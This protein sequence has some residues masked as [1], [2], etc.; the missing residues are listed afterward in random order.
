MKRVVQVCILAVAICLAAAPALFADTVQD[1]INAAA[2]P[3]PA[4]WN[5]SD[6]GWLYTPAASYNLT[7]I[8]TLFGTS[9]TGSNPITEAVFSGLP[10][11]GG[12]LLASA[13]FTGV[14]GSFSGGSFAPLSLVAGQTYFIAFEGVANWSVNVTAD[15]GAVSLGNLYFDFGGT[16][17]GS[18]ETGGADTQPILEFVGNTGSGGTGVPEPSSLFLLASGMLGMAGPMM[19][20]MR[21]KA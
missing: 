20:R 21:M 2:S 15:L 1:S 14:N 3:E 9:G 17:F 16:S 19:R 18:T 13:T 5:A 7:G 8:L 4:F 12:T 10:G 6:V 11:S